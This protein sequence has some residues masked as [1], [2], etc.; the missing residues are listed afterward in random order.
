MS[1]YEQRTIL[2]RIVSEDRIKVSVL[3][4]VIEVKKW[5]RDQI[6]I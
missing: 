3:W 4:G 5:A 1:I 6:A 2:D